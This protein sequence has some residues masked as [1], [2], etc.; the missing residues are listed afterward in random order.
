VIGDRAEYTEACL[1]GRLIDHCKSVSGNV[2]QAAL[3]EKVSSVVSGA[4]LYT[5]S[6]LGAI[7][8]SRTLNFPEVGTLVWGA[9]S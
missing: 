2:K 1:N 8:T 3:H 5:K 9:F 7:A 4:E 6:E